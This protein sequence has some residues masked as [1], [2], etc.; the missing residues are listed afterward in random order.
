METR[1]TSSAMELMELKLESFKSSIT[2]DLK[3][4]L[5]E[6]KKLIKD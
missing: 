6:I 5:S 1:N 4:D 3:S 2:S